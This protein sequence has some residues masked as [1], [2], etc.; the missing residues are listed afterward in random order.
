M[1]ILILTPISPVYS[2]DIYADLVEEYRKTNVS[3]VCFPYFA[4]IRVQNT[5][6]DYLPA[7]FAM[8]KASLEE[9]LHSLIYDRKN[10]IIIGNTY[11][12]EKFDLV[13]QYKPLFIDDVYDKYLETINN[14]PDFEKFKLATQSFELYDENDVDI[15]LT[16]IK[17]I[18]LFLKGVYK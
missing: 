14:D 7:Y 9:E 12:Q 8:I 2:S 17:Q 1:R 18:K 4:E 3:I 16:D 6:L 15:Q 13:I 11:R 5:G 10:M